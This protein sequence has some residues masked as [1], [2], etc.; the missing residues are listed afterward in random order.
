MNVRQC[1]ESLS[2]RQPPL[3]PPPALRSTYTSSPS[4]PSSPQ[5]LSFS[6]FS[7]K[8]RVYHYAPPSL[9]LLSRSVRIS[10]KCSWSGVGLR[11]PVEALQRGKMLSRFESTPRKV[12]NHRSNGNILG[13]INC[14]L[15]TFRFSGH[16]ETCFLSE[17]LQQK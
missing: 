12:Q 14:P 10:T 9:L 3:S 15:K 13:T 2:G 17:V 4:P 11:R 6:P 1:G 5:T 8:P 16:F 7:F